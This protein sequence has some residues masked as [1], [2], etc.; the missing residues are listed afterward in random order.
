MKLYL[1]DKDDDHHFK[2]IRP[3]LL[4]FDTETDGRDYLRAGPEAVTHLSWAIDGDSGYVARIDSVPETVLAWLEDRSIMKTAHN[5]AF[6]IKAVSVALG[7]RVDPCRDTMLLIHLIDP[8]SRSVVPRG[9]KPWGRQ[10]G[11]PYWNAPLERWQE[12]RHYQGNPRA[13]WPTTSS[14]PW[15]PPDSIK[16]PYA[17]ADS[18]ATWRLDSHLMSTLKN[19]ATGSY[20]LLRGLLEMYSK[21]IP[22]FARMELNGYAMDLDKVEEII[23][24]NEGIMDQAG[25]AILPHL[26]VR[27]GDKDWT[28]KFIRSHAQIS[29]WLKIRRLRVL[30]KTKKGNPS[31]DDDVMK[32]LLTKTKEGSVEHTVI[33][34]IVDYRQ[35]KGRSDKLKKYRDECIDGI[36]QTGFGFDR[37]RSGRTGASPNSQNPDRQGGIR[38]CFVSRWRTKE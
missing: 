16:L 15:P 18:L 13:K 37:A 38:D 19:R 25:V 8:A 28:E 35:A 26:G 14:A 36:L 33:Q 1:C 24:T 20:G 23:S 9:L 31:T 29:E 10:V 21:A 5:A 17:A 34:A 3:E 27:P 30:K 4:A 12:E 6:D 22:V 11:M 32:A 2:D 7:L